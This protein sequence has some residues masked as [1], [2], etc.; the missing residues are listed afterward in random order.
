[1][2]LRNTRGGGD[3]FNWGGT[4]GG[5]SPFAA[6]S[7]GG[8][9]QSPST[10]ITAIRCA[11]RNSMLGTALIGATQR[12]VVGS[13]PH[14]VPAWATIGKELHKKEQKQIEKLKAAWD[15]WTLDPS[16]GGKQTWCEMLRGMV[17]DK[18][19]D[20]RVLCLVK[21]DMGYPYGIALLPLPRDHLHGWF[22]GGQYIARVG[23]ENMIAMNGIVRH[24]NG[25]PRGYLINATTLEELEKMQLY[26]GWSGQ[27]AMVSTHPPTLVPAEHVLDYRSFTA[28]DDF[29]AIPLQALATCGT[30]AA[31]ASLDKSHVETMRRAS[32]LFSTLEKSEDYEEPAELASDL[33][34]TSYEPI[35]LYPDTSVI[36]WLPKGV[37]LKGHQFNIPS[38]NTQDYMTQLNA[39]VGAS[40]GVGLG[41]VAGDRRGLDFSALRGEELAIRDQWRMDQA[42]LVERICAPALTAFA[43]HVRVTGQVQLSDAA[44]RAVRMGGWRCRRWMWVDPLKDAK[45]MQELIAIAGAS[46]QTITAMLGVDIDNIIADDK[47]Y[48]EKLKKAGITI[49]ELHAMSGRMKEGASKEGKDDA[50]TSK[51]G[52]DGAESSKKTDN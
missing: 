34:D 51:E 46:P 27:R 31:L 17:A 29:N 2:K 9:Q 12:N 16:V 28:S 3:G 10:S 44:L 26:S 38:L 8:W 30:I 1:M 42:M 32:I 4:L 22:Y 48:L 25:R 18:V 24:P 20:G 49:E 37:S 40:Y 15:E 14:P 43:E 21:Y 41:D 36:E 23:A 19:T 13:G 39:R 45:G 35:V 6:A 33:K 7:L 52:K 47:E 5:G 11:I 50:D